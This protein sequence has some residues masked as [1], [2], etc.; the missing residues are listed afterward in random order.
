MVD[1]RREVVVAR[2]VSK[3]GCVVVGKAG[4]GKE[5]AGDAGDIVKVGALLLS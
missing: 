1:R 4:R 2:G 5:V 3:F